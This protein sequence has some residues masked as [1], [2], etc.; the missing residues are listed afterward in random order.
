M[1][2]LAY[3]KNPLKAQ[4]TTPTKKRDCGRT[5]VVT[6]CARGC[7]AKRKRYYTGENLQLTDCP[8]R[9][10]SASET[11]VQIFDGGPNLAWFE[12]LY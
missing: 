12:N 1:L 2:Q 6:V 4:F 8:T 11:H 9:Q 7:A 5:T 3:F 10:N